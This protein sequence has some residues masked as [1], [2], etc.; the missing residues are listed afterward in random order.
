MKLSLTLKK[1]DKLREF[2]HLILLD[3]DNMNSL[4]APKKILNTLKDAPKDWVGLFPNQYLF[5]YDIWTLRINQYFDYDCFQ[6]FKEYSHHKNI[7]KVYNDIIFKKFFLIK[8]FKNRFI[9]VKSAFGGMGIYKLKL[10]LNSHYD[11]NNGKNCEHVWFNNMIISQNKEKLYI[12]KNLKNSFGLNEH[13][14]KGFFYRSSNYFARKLL[15]KFI[16]LYKQ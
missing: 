4:L 14:L 8:K 15:K 1:I 3:A 6:R 16:L 5:Y 13:I 11:S 9:E 10:V 12:D 7:K 2:D